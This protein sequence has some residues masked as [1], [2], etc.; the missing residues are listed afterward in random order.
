MSQT[1]CELDW[2]LP[3]LLFLEGSRGS[4][5]CFVKPRLTD[6][7]RVAACRRLLELRLFAELLVLRMQR[8]LHVQAAVFAQQIVAYEVHV[9]SAIHTLL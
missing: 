4:K 7:Q 3:N 1:V 6:K 2:P 8:Q 5:I 9:L